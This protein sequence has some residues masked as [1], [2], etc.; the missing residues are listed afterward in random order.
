MQRLELHAFGR[1]LPLQADPVNV[2]AGSTTMKVR[3]GAQHVR[4]MKA[5]VAN[6]EKAILKVASA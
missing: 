2:I 3:T 6:L 1:K 4:S 5:R